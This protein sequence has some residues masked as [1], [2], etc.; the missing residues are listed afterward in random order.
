[1]RKLALA[2]IAYIAIFGALALVRWNLWTYGTDTG[3]FAQVASDALGGFRDGP[4]QGTHFRFHW[5]PLV[6]V[7]GP[8]VLASRSGLALQLAQIVLVAAT[9]WPLYGIARAYVP[10]SRAFAYAALALV[11]PPLGAVA[12][13]EF[14]EIAFYPALALALFWAAERARW[15]WFAVF[16]LAGALVREEACMVLAIAGAVFAAIGFARRDVHRAPGAGLLVGTPREP[17]RLAVAGL[18]CVLVNVAALALYYGAVIPRVGAWQPSRFYDYAFAHG[19]GQLVAALA[20]HPGYAT[21][22]LTWGRATYLLE[23]LVPLA[24]LPLRS[25]WSLLAVPGFLVVLLSSDPI[26]WRMG[27][28][29]AAIWVPWLLLGALATL[30][31]ARNAGGNG[32]AVWYRAALF[33]SAI[34][35]VAFNPMH[36]AHYVR[37][38]Y[39]HDDAV[40]AL[41]T[42]PPGADVVTHD[43]W[44]AHVAFTQRNATVFF[45]PSARFAVF[46]DD[47]PNGYY[48]DEIRP[49]IARE[50]ARGRMRVTATFGR[51]RVYAREPT[52]DANAHRCITPGDVRYTTLPAALAAGR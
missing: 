37:A 31:G 10:S 20:M 51:V 44:F 14:H 11:Y 18:G 47:Y 36:V 46:A 28:H 5:A 48:R 43:E 17:E 34:F 39:P 9:A 25:R 24:F 35:L 33:A 29:Y 38:V 45:C 40:R 32:A 27:S 16:A 1:M 22:I 12:F 23:A 7:L 42:L 4:E 6:A 30:V 19:P 41:A 13:T 50:L 21:Q 3:T 8:L 15:R 26:V 2:T 52:S 49:E